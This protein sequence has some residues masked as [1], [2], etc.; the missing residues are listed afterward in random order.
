MH[1]PK[2]KRPIKK[3]RIKQ[4]LRRHHLPI[5]L[6]TAV[7]I[8]VF[9]TITES[10]DTVFLWSMATAYPGLILLGATLLTGPWKVLRK[11][12]TSVSD[13][14]TRDLGIWAAIVSL[15]HVVA[16][17]QMHMRGRMWLLFIPEDFAFPFIRTDQFGAANYTGLVG[18]LV[19]IFLLLLSNDASMRKLGSS[20]WKNYQRWNYG[21]FALVIAHGILYQVIEKRMLPYVALFTC[22]GILIL[23]GQMAGFFYRKRKQRK[24][25]T[26]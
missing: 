26:T 22:I 7:L 6:A 3:H 14:L 4:R 16:G 10:Q 18:T 2:K 11:K 8:A 21:L 15:L 9:Y 20:K 1:A 12:T 5:M 25:N 24:L 13:D 23:V 17:L 19:V